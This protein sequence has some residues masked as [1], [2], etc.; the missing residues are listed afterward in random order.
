MDHGY[1][2]WPFNI[3]VESIIMVLKCY[4]IIEQ[5]ES[6]MKKFSVEP[7]IEILI[8]LSLTLIELEMRI[9]VRDTRAVSCTTATFCLF[10]TLN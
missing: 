7:S 6:L 10:E 2:K 8:Q 5:N 9:R 3:V 1:L 4:S